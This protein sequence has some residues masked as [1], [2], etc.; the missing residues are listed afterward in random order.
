MKLSKAIISLFIALL[1]GACLI[2]QETSQLKMTELNSLPTT[3]IGE[4]SLG[5]A[6]MMGGVHHNIVIAG[7]GANFPDDLP[8]EGGG[9]EWYSTIYLMESGNW[10]LSATVFPMP[11]AYGAS[12]STDDGVLIIGGDNREGVSDKVFLLSYNKA[13]NNLD[14]V[15]YPDL[16]EPLAYTAAVISDGYVY[17]AGGMNAEKST[18]SFYR[19]DLKKKQVWEKLADFPGEPRAV[20][21]MAVQETSNSRNIFLIGG[22]DQSKGQLSKPLTRYLSYDLNKKEWIDKG[23]LMVNGRQKVLMGAVAETMGSMH[24]LVYGGSDEVLFRELEALGKT[25]NG[26]GNDSLVNSSIA[27][28][29]RI[30][31]N[32]PGFSHEI[33][34]FNTITDQWFVLD[35]VPVQ[36]PMTTLGIKKDKD[37]LIVSGEISP[38][39]RTPN[40]YS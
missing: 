5:F 37:L 17:V 16:P 23:D 3:V 32:H 7:G 27:Q 26:G 35:S 39:I 1:F 34:T 22:R 36:L 19:M 28:R 20:H 10:R 31:N 4:N 29:D 33:L 9:K 6:G 18:N 38:G 8:W 15:S 13:K 40:V 14:L 11:L 24:I 25:I 30:L 12:V 21:A 2:A